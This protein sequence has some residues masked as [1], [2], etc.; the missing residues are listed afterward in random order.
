MPEKSPEFWIAIWNALPEPIKAALL[1]VSLA[2]VMAFK[3]DGRTLRDKITD[4]I[5]GVFL[6][7]IGG[8]V[9][10][11]M[12]FS[13]GWT[14]ALAGALGGYGIAP[15]KQFVKDVTDRALSWWF[16]RK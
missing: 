1:Y 15:T 13:E 10:S 5:A 8:S 6:V 3:H 11:L 12:G 16:S 4:C 9:V 14:F 2:L 7:L